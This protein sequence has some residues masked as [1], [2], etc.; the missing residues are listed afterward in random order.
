VKTLLDAVQ[1]GGRWEPTLLEITDG[2]PRVFTGI[3]MRLKLL[4]GGGLLQISADRSVMR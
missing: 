4:H 2:R 3:A 1:P